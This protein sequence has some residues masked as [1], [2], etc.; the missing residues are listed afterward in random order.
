[1]RPVKL[2]TVV[3]GYAPTKTDFLFERRV[4]DYVYSVIAE[5]S[6]SKPSLIFCRSEPL[7]VPAVN[8]YAAILQ[9]SCL[10]DHEMTLSCTSQQAMPDCNPFVN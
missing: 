1:M 9:S 8:R 3:K 4:T 5:H 10:Q 7:G 6:K 2:R